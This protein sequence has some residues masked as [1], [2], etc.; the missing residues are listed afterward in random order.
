MGGEFVYYCKRRVITYRDSFS[1]VDH[2][3]DID[4]ISFLCLR[5][6]NLFSALEEKNITS[7]QVNHFAAQEGCS[8]NYTDP[9]TGSL[10]WRR[11]KV[12]EPVKTAVDKSEYDGVER[13]N[14]V[15]VWL[16]GGL[17]SF[18][19]I[20][21]QNPGFLNCLIQAF[22]LALCDLTRLDLAVDFSQNIMPYVTSSIEK[23]YYDCHLHPYGY[24]WLGGKSMKGRV[25][26]N[27]ENA[28]RFEK[29]H[30]I[31]HTVSFGS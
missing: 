25:G 19:R 16:T 11:K 20:K 14:S 22:K 28:E 6:P 12:G 2:K 9:Q 7:P 30:L 8:G 3:V 5:S 10:L 21:K 23:G 17:D 1:N 4:G 24:G 18:L 13:P 27:S 29:E 31:L 26:K 15:Y